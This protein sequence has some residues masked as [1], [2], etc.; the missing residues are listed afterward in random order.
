MNDSS[1]SYF[2]DAS[3]SDVGSFFSDESSDESPN[4]IISSD[5]ESPIIDD[6]P[7]AEKVEIK[8]DSSGCSMISLSPPA[9]G[10][11]TKSKKS[12]TP[13]TTGKS[14]LDC[15][16]MRTRRR[17]N[18]LTAQSPREP[19]TS[20]WENVLTEKRNRGNTIP[21]VSNTLSKLS[22]LRSKFEGKFQ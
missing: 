9:G 16:S 4:I 6:F 2:S 14:V 22:N 13:K 18:A 8:L 11:P 7:N 1:S 3:T 19:K 15:V 5:S 12:S 20:K 10:I 17:M 21:A